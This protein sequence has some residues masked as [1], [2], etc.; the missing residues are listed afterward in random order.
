[1]T[2]ARMSNLAARRRSVSSRGAAKY[3][4]ER[5]QGETKRAVLKGLIGYNRSKLGKRGHATLTVSIRNRK[6]AIAGGLVGSIWLDWLYVNLVFI[7]DR[8]R[9]GGAGRRLITTAEE[10]ARR[11]GATHV[12]L[13]SFTFQAPDFYKKLGYREFGRLQDFPPGHDRVFLTKA[14]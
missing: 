1:M 5:R 13:D 8:Y 12:Y 9:G 2:A 4:V 3:A 11:R 6:G 14:L 7:D 10:E